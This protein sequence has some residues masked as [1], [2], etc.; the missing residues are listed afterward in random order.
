MIAAGIAAVFVV[1]GGAGFGAQRLLAKRAPEGRDT[2]GS[3]AASARSAA[4]ASGDTA[5]AATSAAAPSPAAEITIKLDVE[6]KDAIVELD[7]APVTDGTIRMPRGDATHALRVHAPGYATE[8]RDVSARED[9]ALAIA[10]K[11][12]PA[13]GG[14]AGRPGA[15]SRGATA[16]PPDSPAKKVKGPLE[17]NL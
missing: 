6:P 3:P 4:A 13:V 14:G 8:A 16:S 7:G 5:A 11:R 12:A 1:A 9:G 17:T 15:P 2:T 10:L